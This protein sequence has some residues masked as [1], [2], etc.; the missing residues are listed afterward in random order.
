MNMTRETKSM[1]V[2]MERPHTF[3]ELNEA[4]TEVENEAVAEQQRAPMA[5]PIGTPGHNSRHQGNQR[6]SRPAVTCWCFGLTGHLARVCDNKPAQQN[7]RTVQ[8]KNIRGRR[9]PRPQFN[10]N[11]THTPVAKPQERNNADHCWRCG[12]VGHW[13]AAC[14]AP[15]GNIS[16]QTPSQNVRAKN[17]NWRDQGN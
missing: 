8:A 3:R 17:N 2:L 9:E 12:E 16:K 10:D 11:S 6:M 5:Q 4:V 15:R 13:Q 7:T 1:F 14:S